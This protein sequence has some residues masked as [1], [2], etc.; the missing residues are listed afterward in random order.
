MIELVTYYSRLDSTLF[1][2]NVNAEEE[3]Q[4]VFPQN[5]A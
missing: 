5:M 3:F 2:V 1:A 4:T